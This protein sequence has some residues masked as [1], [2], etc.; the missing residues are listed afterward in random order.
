MGDLPAARVNVARPFEHCGLDYCGPMYVKRF[1]KTEK[2]YILL[3]TCL[4]S[5]AVHLELAGA[6]D[7]DCFLMAL[8]RFIARRGSPA[9]ITSDNGSN[10]VSGERELR[11]AL[12]E[13]DQVRISDELSSRRIQWTF[14]PPAASHMGGVW[15]RLVSSVKRALRTVLGRQ[16]VSEDVLHT[17]L[18]EVE[19]M[20]N[21]RPL[22]Y[23]SGDVRDPEPLTPNHF[24]LGMPQAAVSPGVFGDKEVMSRSKWRQSQALAELMWKRWQKEYLPLLLPRKKWNTEVDNLAEGDVVLMAEDDSPRGF[25]PLAR[26]TEVI[27]GEDGRVRSVR[28]QTASKSVYHR[29]VSKI[30]LIEKCGQ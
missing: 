9:S 17:V 25:W 12:N 11:E 26:V 29:P 21:S 27:P 19:Y 30:C 6:L 8:R 7:T 10:L 5:R 23:S 28:V 4:A 2:R 24:L 13:L 3:I 22:T 14:I 1:R 18:T 16:C 15:E 20:L